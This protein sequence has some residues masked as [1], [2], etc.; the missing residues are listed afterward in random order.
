MRR[1]ERLNTALDRIAE[2]IGRQ[3][4]LEGRALLTLLQ[5]EANRLELLDRE[6]TGLFDR[7][8]SD[9]AGSSRVVMQETIQHYRR[10]ME[11][12]QSE[13][14]SMIRAEA[15]L[16][17]ARVQK[18]RSAISG[19]QRGQTK[20]VQH[21]H[22]AAIK[23]RNL[24]GV[25]IR[26][27]VRI[28]AEA[29]RS[30]YES[31]LSNLDRQAMPGPEDLAESKL[32]VLSPDIR[33]TAANLGHA[34]LAIYQYVHNRIVFEPYFG[35]M[36]NAQAVLWSG[37]AND[38]DQAT[39]LIALLRAANT[40][41]RYVHG[42]MRIPVEQAMNWVGAK[43]R[44]S[45]RNMLNVFPG[46]EE[47]EE[48]FRIEHFWVEAWIDAGAGHEWIPL[49]P[50]IKLKQY[51]PGLSVADVVFDRQ[52]FLSSHKPL[53]SVLASESYLE[54]VRNYLQ[55]NRPGVG[56]SDVAFDG[57]I[58][59]DNSTSLPKLASE[60]YELNSQA[61]EIAPELH[62]RAAVTI[63]ISLN[64]APVKAE[65]SLPETTLQS[66]TASF[67]AASPEAQQVIDSY[68]GIAST[69]IGLLQL[70]PQ[71]RVDDQVVATGSSP[72]TQIHV[73]TLK[74][75]Y[76]P[77]RSQQPSLHCPNESFG[78][79]IRRGRR[80]HSRRATRHGK[81]RFLSHRALVQPDSRRLERATLK[82]SGANCFI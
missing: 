80:N 38:L 29:S 81:A 32:V 9:G 44:A 46:T 25:D 17:G 59:P 62:H 63:D 31:P 40:P 52:Q 24:T 6:F 14:N 7:I 37:R 82:K 22:V 36:Q 12:I 53:P 10:R 47:I 11:A 15:P 70:V 51:Q 54:E 73:T 64:Q 50:S 2:L 28:V 27:Q 61:S 35:A 45:A 8:E 55:T 42:T 75:E 58:I 26:R 74:V 43:D 21:R 68:G 34:P 3:S 71:I 77:P 60:L 79:R 65:I 41:A 69:P 5:A 72:L 16:S 57:P 66:V 33:A 78:L 67:A 30:R 18:L 49:D 4:E 76:F 56:L 1:V 19:R 23:H 39:L 20:A 13:L 48:A